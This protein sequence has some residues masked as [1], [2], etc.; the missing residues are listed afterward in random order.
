MLT[1]V[2]AR[3]KVTVCIGD[4]DFPAKGAH[5]VV[6]VPGWISNRI[7]S[8]KKIDL[9]KLKMVVFDEADE[10]FL[11]QSNQ[12]ELA[13]LNSHLIETLKI[14]PQMVLFSATYTDAVMENV[15][16]FVAEYQSFRIPTQ[17]LKLKG[18]KMFRIKVS[19]AEKIAFIKDCYLEFETS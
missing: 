9:S 8:R 19:P 3:T 5:I 17:S 15:D 11:Q 4:V 6:T 14:Q 10:I 12:K 16:K 1:R 13:K 2:S 18:V 7:S